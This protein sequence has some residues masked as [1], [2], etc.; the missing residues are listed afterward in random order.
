MDY[1]TVYLEEN[2]S[3][4]NYQFI[5]GKSFGSP[6]LYGDG[7]LDITSRV[8]EGLNKKYQSEKK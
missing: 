1:I 7:G 8:T 5:L 2:K 6:V 3:E 4:Y